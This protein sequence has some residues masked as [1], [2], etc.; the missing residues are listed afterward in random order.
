MSL[1]LK[2]QE[3]KFNQLKETPED[4][5]TDITRLANIAYADSGGNKYSIERTRQKLD[6]FIS[7]MP[8]HIRFKILM[9]P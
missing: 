1:K 5:V 3:R 4:F 8:T 6:A 7:R 9:Q 2:F